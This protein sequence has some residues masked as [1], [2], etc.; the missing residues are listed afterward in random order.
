[1][2]AAGLPCPDTIFVNQSQGFFHAVDRLNGFPVVVKPVSQRQ[3]EGI[4]LITDLDDARKR[5]LPALD[6]RR[7]LLVQHYLPPDN[8]RDIRALVIDGL[9]ICAATLVPSG[10]DFRTNFHLG[11]NIQTTTLSEEMAQ[12]A[13]GAAAAVGCDVAGVD[14]MIDHHDQP[15]IAEV[16]YAP[17][18]R[19]MEAATGLDIASRIIDLAANRYHRIKEGTDKGNE[20]D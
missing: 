16:N 14:M 8:R 18:F 17:G 1:L 3:G 20:T 6:R 11:G 7:G 2:T 5:A 10:N 15:H 12:I 19:G 9:L 13:V 4:L